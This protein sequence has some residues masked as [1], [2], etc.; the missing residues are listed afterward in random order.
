VNDAWFEDVIR[1]EEALAARGLTDSPGTTYAGNFPGA[2]PYVAGDSYYGYTKPQLNAAIARRE[3]QSTLDK[4]NADLAK[5]ALYTKLVQKQITAL[6]D[7][8]NSAAHGHYDRF[9]KTDVANMINEVQRILAN[10]TT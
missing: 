3:T 10:R 4:M 7:I 8:R 9:S 1:R 6:A 2:N 5:A